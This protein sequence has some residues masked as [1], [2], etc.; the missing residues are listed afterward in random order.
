MTS[1]INMSTTALIAM[2][3]DGE[4][5]VF[6]LILSKMEGTGVDIFITPSNLSMQPD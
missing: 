2:K 4:R 5:P 1:G 3:L 6:A